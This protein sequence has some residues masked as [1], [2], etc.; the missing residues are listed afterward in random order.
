MK[1]LEGTL[2]Y[3]D[4]E[5]GFWGLID[6]S[7]DKYVLFEGLSDDMKKDGLRVQATVEPANVLGTAMWGT[8]VRVVSITPSAT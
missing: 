1:K 2:S 5:G 6:A 3:Q 8:Y 4:L 7:G